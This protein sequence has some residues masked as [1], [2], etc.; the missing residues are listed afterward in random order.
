MV[1]LHLIGNPHLDSEYP[2]CYNYGLG[3]RYHD[4]TEGIFIAR[5]RGRRIM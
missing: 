2:I 5:H 4:K 3:F 1:S